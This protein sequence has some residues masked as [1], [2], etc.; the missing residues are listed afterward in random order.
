MT[1]PDPW[2]EVDRLIALAKASTF[3]VGDVW[4]SPRCFRFR[5]EHVSADGTATFCKD[6]P[7]WSRT[8]SMRWNSPKLSGWQLLERGPGPDDGGEGEA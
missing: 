7:G 4:L 5:V 1:T 8:V 3:R 6:E 2:A